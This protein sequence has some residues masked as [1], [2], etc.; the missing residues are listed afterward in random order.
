MGFTTQTFLF[1]FFPLCMM[2]YGVLDVA[3]RLGRFGKLLAK[4]RLKDLTLIVFSLCFYMWAVR[5]DAVLLLGYSLLVYLCGVLIGIYKHKERSKTAKICTVIGVVALLICL[6]YYKYTNFIVKVITGFLQTDFTIGSIMAPL[7]ISFITFSAISYLVDVYRGK[8]THGSVIDCLLYITFFPKVVSGPIVLWKDF[9]PQIQ[10]RSMSLEQSIQGI[11]RIMIGFAKKI[12]LADVFGACLAQ[13][14]NENLDAITILGS[15]LLY[16]LQIY[17]DFAGYSDIAI[18]I[19]NL[20]GFRFSNNFN[21]P[22]RSTSISEF[23]RHWHISLG[24][25]FR[26]YVYFPLGGS[27]VST[28]KTL[29]NL[30]IVFALTGIWHGAGWNYIIWGGINAVAVLAERL[31]QNTKI[32]QKTPKWIKY[33]VTMGI[34]LFF[35][36]FFRFQSVSEIVR[37]FGMLFSNGGEPAIAWQYY[38]DLRVIIFA[39]IGVLGATVLGDP[40]VVA[41]YQKWSAKPWFYVVQELVLLILFVLS[42]LFMVNSTYS[43]FIY[44]QY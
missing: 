30:G 20:F 35:W 31:L 18:G 28:L 25:W 15:I 36:Q 37:L 5:F 11:N 44:F 10:N 32:Y 27:R 8:A 21:F 39:V 12:L 2:G 26:E 17:Y 14:G 13:I 19:S 23:W 9:Q 16:F 41:L 7:G 34:V 24:T 29:R 6:I 38:F 42:V 33:I 22:Y 4:I 40:R 43:P 1:V 3:G